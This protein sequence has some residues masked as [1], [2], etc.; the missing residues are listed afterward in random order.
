MSLALIRMHSL[1]LEM[2]G[3]EDGLRYAIRIKYPPNPEKSLAFISMSR[4]F[5]FFLFLS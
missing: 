3:K 4:A 1:I 5:S 2:K